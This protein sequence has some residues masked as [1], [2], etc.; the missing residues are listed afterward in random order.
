MLVSD[1]KFFK[2]SVVCFLLLFIIIYL[3]SIFNRT[4]HGDEA[5]IAEHAYWFNKIGYVKSQMYDG[6]GMGWETR[7]FHYHK[8][9]VLA[10]A[11]M[12]H[13][14]GVSLMALRSISI[15]FT[16]VCIYFLSLYSK[17][18]TDEPKKYFFLVSLVILLANFVFFDFSL[19]YRPEIMVTAFGFGSFYFLHK[20]VSETKL[21]FIV[22]AGAFSGLSALTH[23]NGVCYVVT[24]FVLLTFMK[25]YR[26]A[27]IYGFVGTAFF[28]LYFFDINTIVKFKSFW[29]QFTNDPNL[30]KEKFSFF[31]P[32]VRIF[33]E[34]MR[35]FWDHNIASFSLLFIVTLVFFY[36]Q[37]KQDHSFLLKYLIIF[38]LI[39]AFISHG[40]TVKYIIV[41]LPFMVLLIASGILKLNAL[42]KS[43]KIIY[44]SL[45]C[46]YLGINSFSIVLKISRSYNSVKRTELI[47]TYLPEKNVNVLV[48]ENFFFNGINKYTLHI[49]LAFNYIH[50]VYLKTK[51]TTED[52][53]QFAQ[54]R[55]NK[56]IILDKLVDPKQGLVNF[57]SLYEKEIIFR[58][59]V[60]KKE[61]DFAILEL[62]Q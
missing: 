14:F 47:C 50:E 9:F 8:L 7:Q 35:F 5:I 3:Y 11:L 27:F 31:T 10:G 34:Q 12:I 36:K 21:S 22:L 49:P 44:V 39:F 60:I 56:Y 25:K 58:Y 2:A 32:F 38:F 42:S 13:F 54:A 51:P 43:K 1:K 23:L 6:M 26:E 45:L 18:K 40:P 61:K 59:T 24:G 46:I 29:F 4:V 17:A 41:Y 37:I 19:L 57:E 16:F 48:K 20:A 15:V 30:D 33:T 55:N 52:F 53:F 28:L 62:N